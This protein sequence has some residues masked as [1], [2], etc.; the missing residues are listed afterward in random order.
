MAVFYA[1]ML[2]GA[3]LACALYLMAVEFFIAHGDPEDFE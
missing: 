1:G 2:A 3:L